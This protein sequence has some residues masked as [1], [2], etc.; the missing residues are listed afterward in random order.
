M[1][2][3]GFYLL[4]VTGDF[5]LFPFGD[6]LVFLCAVFFALHILCVDHFLLQGASGVRVAWIQFAMTFLVS[7]LGALVWETLPAAGLGPALW[8]A[9]WPLLYTA[10]LSSGV[11]YTLQIVGQKYTDPT[12]ATLIMSLESVFAVL[13][14]WLFLG[15]VMTL[16]EIIG[17]GL[18]FAAVLLAQR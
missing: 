10:G 14:G 13:A 17:C 9:R 6:F 4:C 8:A 16:R 18:V 3:V 5:H 15:E 11:A 12:T 1:A 7:L 2:L